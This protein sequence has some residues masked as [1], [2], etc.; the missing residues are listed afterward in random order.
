MVDK[1]AK[2]VLNEAG[3]G[4]ETPL[5]IKPLPLCMTTAGTGLNVAA[6]EITTVSLCLCHFQW[7]Y[8]LA[9]RIPRNTAPH[10]TLRGT[11]RCFDGASA[12]H[13]QQ[14]VGQE[15]SWTSGRGLSVNLGGSMLCRGTKWAEAAA[16]SCKYGTV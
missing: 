10:V 6:A 14:F 8:L 11:E 13:Q 1:K 16:V 7:F 2:S 5:C 9:V 12:I 15:H 3:L 4:T